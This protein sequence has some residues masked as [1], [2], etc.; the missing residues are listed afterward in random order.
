MASPYGNVRPQGYRRAA[1]EAEDGVGGIVLVFALLAAAYGPRQK[2]CEI[3]EDPRLARLSG[4]GIQAGY[5]GAFL[6]PGDAKAQVDP[7]T[8][9]GRDGKPGWAASSRI[10]SKKMKLVAP[11]QLRW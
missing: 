6:E 8:K 3:A 2:K 5:R 7:G 11:S 10:T 1:A 4:L 9:G